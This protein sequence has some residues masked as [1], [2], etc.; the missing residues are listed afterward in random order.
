M[1]KKKVFEELRIFLV[2]LLVVSSLRSALADWGASLVLVVFG[3]VVYAAWSAVDP[4]S[5]R[6]R[7]NFE[8]SSLIRS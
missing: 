8:M 3:L 4:T 5:G 7:S 1:T 2:M 6:S